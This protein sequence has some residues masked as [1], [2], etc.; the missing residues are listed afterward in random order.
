MK[1]SKHYLEYS[2]KVRDYLTLE[3][4]EYTLKNYLSAELQADGRMRYWA[5]IEKY[6]KYLRVVV[7]N[8]GE[9]IVTAFFDRNYIYDKGK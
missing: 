3:M 2:S 8:D 1:F 6:N 5:H 7:E 9:T 4:C